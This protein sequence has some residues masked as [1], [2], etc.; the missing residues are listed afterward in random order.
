MR[1]QGN[2][3]SMKNLCICKFGEIIQFEFKKFMI[4]KAGI[5]IVE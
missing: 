2:Y 1:N 4:E 5:G 3:F